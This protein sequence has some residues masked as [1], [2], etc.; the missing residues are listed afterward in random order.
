ME[1]KDKC[2]VHAHTFIPSVERLED[3]P[4]LIQLAS[5]AKDTEQAANNANDNELK[6]IAPKKPSLKTVDSN[7]KNQRD[8]HGIVGDKSTNFGKSTIVGKSASD[9]NSSGYCNKKAMQMNPHRNGDFALP[10]MQRLPVK[11]SL[12]GPDYKLVTSAA[13]GKVT[14]PN[15]SSYN[16]VSSKVRNCHY[17]YPCLVWLLSNS[18]N[19]YMSV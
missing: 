12:H 13:I 18:I 17:N 2:R 11:S 4:S 15:Q 3:N 14:A 5:K 9:F 6:N 19:S 10:N 16:L 7:L 8:S 1:H